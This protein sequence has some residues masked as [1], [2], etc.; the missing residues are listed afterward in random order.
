MSEL[1]NRRIGRFPFW[2]IFLVNFAA[3]SALKQNFPVLTAEHGAVSLLSGLL[4]VPAFVASVWRLHDIGQGA[5]L[6]VASFVSNL[7]A[8]IVVPW[9]GDLWLLY[10][11]HANEAMFLRP[12]NVLMMA[13]NLITFRM[14]ALCTRPSADGWRPRERAVVEDELEITAPSRPAPVSAPRMTA[15][16]PA[17]AYTPGPQNRKSFGRRA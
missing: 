17:P 11:P 1:L 14:L 12:D 7:L 15:V 2:A 3:V 5:G 6:A 16:P 9:L 4:F 8:G 10:D 13:L